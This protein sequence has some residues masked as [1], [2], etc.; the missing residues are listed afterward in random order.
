MA[1][2]FCSINEKTSGDSIDV[3]D[4]TITDMSGNILYPIDPKQPFILNLKAFNKG[5]QVSKP[6]M[7]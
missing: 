6:V 1:Y 5:V 7:L 4:V 2:F 3:S